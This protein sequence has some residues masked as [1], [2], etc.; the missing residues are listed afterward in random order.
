MADFAACSRFT[1][2]IDRSVQALHY[3]NENW[4]TRSA[5]AISVS[6]LDQQCL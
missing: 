3:S 2:L 1:D 5:R 4:E 6:L